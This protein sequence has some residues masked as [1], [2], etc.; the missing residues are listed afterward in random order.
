MPSPH[1]ERE[2]LRE[3]TYTARIHTSPFTL[4]MHMHTPYTHD[5]HSHTEVVCL[6]G[7]T[8]GKII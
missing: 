8:P 7:V 4:N 6:Y 1:M 2:N 5:T 3:T